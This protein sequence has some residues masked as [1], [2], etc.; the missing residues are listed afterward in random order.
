MIQLQ[1]LQVGNIRYCSKF[2][3]NMEDGGPSEQL[4]MHQHHHGG[5]DAPGL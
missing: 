3:E 1:I 4:V 5:F 2:L